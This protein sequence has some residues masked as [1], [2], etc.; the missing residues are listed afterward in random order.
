MA[1]A[2]L[3][4]VGIVGVRP[5]AGEGDGGAPGVGVDGGAVVDDG[6]GG[7]GGSGGGAQS[8]IT[9]SDGSAITWFPGQAWMVSGKPFLLLRVPAP[10]L[11]YS[12]LPPTGP[13]VMSLVRGPPLFVT[14]PP[15]SVAGVGARIVMLSLVMLV[16]GP[17]VPVRTYSAP[18]PAAGQ[19]TWSCAGFNGA[20]CVGK[21]M[22]VLLGSSTS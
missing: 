3:G 18:M 17:P 19:R 8:E 9:V 10:G 21:N 14:E 15:L 1:I 5:G 16:S 6:G 22:P 13:A 12:T 2:E 7:A 20:H 11:P 4:G